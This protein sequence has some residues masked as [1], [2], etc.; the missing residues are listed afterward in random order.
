MYE[1]IL[2]RNETDRKKY[3]KNAT[4][5]LGKHYV[6]MEREKSLANPILLDVARPH[7]I[8]VSGKR[9]SGKSYTLGVMAEGLLNLEKGIKENISCI[10]FDTLGIY[11]TM[12][13][14]N[15]RDDALHIALA[16]IAN[17]DLLVSWNFRHIVRYDKIR[18]FNS[19]NIESGYK[20]IQIY[21][22]R[23]VT[24]YGKED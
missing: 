12:K 18:L 22:P 19:V 17:V 6:T 16:T 5:F 3:G 21:S 11:W 13:Y 24:S 1:I 7:V 4:I 2:G 14:P 10:I 8:L 20:P 9:G 15:Y 23:E